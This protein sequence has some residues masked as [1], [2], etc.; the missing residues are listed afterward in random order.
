MAYDYPLVTVLL[1]G[2]LWRGCHAQMTS[3]VE[4]YCKHVQVDFNVNIY[5]PTMSCAVLVRWTLSLKD[6]FK[7]P[8]IVLQK[9]GFLPGLSLITYHTAS[10]LR[11]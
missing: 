11:H 8:S 10:E 5:Q 2:C 6:K 4:C 3:T 1:G 7:T 9:V